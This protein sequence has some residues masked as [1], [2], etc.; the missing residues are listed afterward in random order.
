MINGTI[1]KQTLRANV[2]LWLIFTIVLTILQVVMIAVFDASTLTDVSQLV[3]GTPLAGLLGKTTLLSMLASTFYSIHGVI[4]P[5][6]FI[7]MTA[8]SLIASQVDRGSM[9][10]LLSTPTKRST[11]IV[12]QAFYLIIALVVMFFIET[13]AG[14]VTIQVFQSNTDIVVADFVMLNVGLLL[15]MFAISGISF[16]FSSYCNLTKNSL[17]FGAGI[18]IAFFLFQLLSSV[19]ESLNV[20]NY[21]TVNALFDTTAILEGENYWW[22]LLILLGIGIVLYIASLEVFKRKDLPL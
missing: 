19:D 9:A 4:F 18:P 6:I 14:L 1:F 22:K 15:L 20:L 2:K 21:F 10:Y 7:I 12:T 17:A 3:E 13:A 8:N 5:I 16:F 11:I